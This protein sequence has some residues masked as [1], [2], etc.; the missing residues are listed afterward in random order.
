VLAPGPGLEADRLSP[1]PGL[2]DRSSLLLVATH[3]PDQPSKATT[4]WCPPSPG[5]VAAPARAHPPWLRQRRARG[6]PTQLEI[7]AATDDEHP[8]LPPD[9]AGDEYSQLRPDTEDDFSQLPPG[10]DDV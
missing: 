1:V 9:V 10:D 6:P 8:Q 7:V 2:S 3:P 4:S 5:V